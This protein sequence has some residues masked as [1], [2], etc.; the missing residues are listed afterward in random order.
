MDSTELQSLD[1]SRLLL[2]HAVLS[3][4]SSLSYSPA[5]NTPLSLYGLLVVTKTE[6]SNDGGDSVRQFSGLLALSFLLD[7]FWLMSSW[8]HMSSGFAILLILGN[9]FLKPITLLAALGHLRQRGEPTFSL[10]TGFSI[11]GSFPPNSQRE[12]VWSAPGGYH[13]IQSDDP[14]QHHPPAPAPAPQRAAGPPHPAPQAQAPQQQQQS[15]STPVRGGGEG[16]GYHTL[17]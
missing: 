12:T 11:P 8:R 13:N 9:F 14:Y 15:A 10:P 3:L 2:V 17:E 6:A 7:L 16:G 4:V 5:W 1:L